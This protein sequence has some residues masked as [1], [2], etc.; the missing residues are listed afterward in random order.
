MSISSRAAFV[1][2]TAYTKIHTTHEY[3]RKKGCFSDKMTGK[4]TVLGGVV[5]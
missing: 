5:Q 1:L 3:F 2:M 4:Y